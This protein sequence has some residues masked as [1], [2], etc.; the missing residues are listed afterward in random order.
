M[1]RLPLVGIALSAVAVGTAVAGPSVPATPANAVPFPSTSNAA[2]W[3]TYEPSGRVARAAAWHWTAAGGNCCETYVATTGKRLLEFGGTQPFYSD[4]R[5]ASWH[6]V[7]FLTP[8]VNGEGALVAGPGGDVFGIGWDPY[9]GDRL[10]A[11]RYTARTQSWEV[12]E[13][14]LKTPF[15]DR[16]WITYAKGPFVV[17]GVTVPFVTIVRGG[18]VTRSIE[19]ISGDGLSYTTLSSPGLEAGTP[20][21]P[22]TV[23]VVPNAAADD[24]QPNPGTHTV[25]LNAGGVLLLNNDSDQLPCPAARLNATTL[26]WQCVTLPWT[27]RGVVR[28]DSRGWLTQTRQ[29]GPTQFELSLSPDGGRTWR[30]VVLST[31]GGGAIDADFFDVK[32]SGRLGQAVVAT[33]ATNAAGQGQDLVWRVDVARRQPRLVRTYTVGAGDVATGSDITAAAGDRYDFPSVALLP[34]GRIA[35]S[36]FDRRTAGSPALAVLD[37]AR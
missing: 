35:S 7:D 3:T 27:P 30:E 15:F 6:R 9:A 20:A 4:D 8:G 36:F 31:P 18:G 32:V 11:V 26:R 23:P 5:G 33:R 24:W 28:Q 37:S 34:D 29:L 25:P 22:L 19:L 14:P 2:T 13:A 16:E 17:D 10:Q 21:V 1:R 12:A